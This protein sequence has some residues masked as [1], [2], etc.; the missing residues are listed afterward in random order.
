MNRKPK[1]TR[2]D[3]ASDYFINLCLEAEISVQEALH[4]GLTDTDLL[5]IAEQNDFK[6]IEL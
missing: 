4:F 6:Y 2:L 5:R 1:Y 3:R